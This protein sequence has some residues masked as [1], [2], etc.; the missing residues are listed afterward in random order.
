MFGTSAI[1]FWL[2]SALAQSHQANATPVAPTDYFVEANTNVLQSPTTTGAIGGPIATSINPATAIY[3]VPATD[4]YNTTGGTLV[5][6]GNAGASADLSTGQLHA[7][8]GATANTGIAGFPA[9]ATATL[10]DTLYFENSNASATTVTSIGF[11][12]HVDGTQNVGYNNGGA[13]FGLSI[14]PD[15]GGVPLPSGFNPQSFQCSTTITT[16][17]VYNGYGTTGDW[18]GYD[19]VV[20]QNFIGS[21]SF[22]GPSAAVSIAMFVE[23]MGQYGYTD[24]SDTASFSF[25]TLP[26]GVSYTSAS[27]NFLVGSQSVPESGTLPIFVTAFLGFIFIQRRRFIGSHV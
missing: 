5:S 19:A 26:S 17:C 25:D 7:A 23:A 22:K 12:A 21:F 2:G 3:Y 4:S 18:P 27:G 24:F 16:D 20:N 6:L 10:G 13:E 14:G 1:I 9:S 15:G 11:I 8:A